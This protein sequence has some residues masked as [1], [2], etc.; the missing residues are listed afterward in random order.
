MTRLWLGA[1]ILVTTCGAGIAQQAPTAAIMRLDTTEQ[2]SAAATR[3]SERT[4]KVVGV[5][6][7][8]VTQVGMD[9]MVF[10][11]TLDT[12]P[13][14]KLIVV[15]TPPRDYVVM[16]NGVRKKTTERSE[17]IVPPGTMVE[18]VVTRVDIPPCTWKH[19]VDTDQQVTC[20][21]P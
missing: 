8:T 17:Y 16:L 13:T 3:W 11:K 9:L 5:L 18:L 2:F 15:P 1:G 10:E 14:I 4:G 19:R 21:L 7:A 20:P 6:P 12:W